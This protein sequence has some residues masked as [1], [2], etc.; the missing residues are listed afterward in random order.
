MKMRKILPLAL[1]AIASVF[2]LSSCDALLDAIFA[3]NTINIYVSADWTVHGYTG[4]DYVSFQISNG[5]TIVTGNLGYSGNDSRYMYWDISV[6]DLPDGTYT[7]SVVY[8]HPFGI[9]PFGNT[10]DST[11]IYLP[12]HSGNKHNVNV[13]FAPF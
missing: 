12:A 10:P 9:A 1:L 2:L 5:S 11:V 6:P 8:H 7:V 13:V 3:K 4:T